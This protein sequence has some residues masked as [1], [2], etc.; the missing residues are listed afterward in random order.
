MPWPMNPEN[1]EILALQALGWL[2]GDEDGLERFLSLSGLD[3]AALRRPAGS[4]DTECRDSGL[5]AG[6]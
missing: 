3:A 2:A 6:S 4:P 5:S 1:A